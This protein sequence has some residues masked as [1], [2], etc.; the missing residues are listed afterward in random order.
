MPTHIEH[1]SPYPRQQVHHL[2]PES[3]GQAFEDE[4]RA[5]QADRLRL[6]A[7]RNRYYA[8]GRMLIA[9]L[10]LV[11][12]VLKLFTFDQTRLAMQSMG[13]RDATVLLTGAIVVEI[14]GGALIAVGYRVRNAAIGMIIYLAAI[15]LVMHGDVTVEANRISIL[16]NLAFIGAL[17]M[18]VGHGA[19]PL[20]V[21]RWLKRANA[22]R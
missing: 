7:Q 5:L 8:A 22:I 2:D 4:L 17:T 1:V 18:L 14:I 10:F 13:L 9:P 6:K 19:G 3:A 12:A 15:T 11:G 21:D 20:S 16:A